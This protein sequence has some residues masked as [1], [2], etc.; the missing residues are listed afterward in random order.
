MIHVVA[1]ANGLRGQPEGTAELADGSTLPE[2]VMGRLAC[3]ASLVAH[4]LEGGSEPLVLGRKVRDWTPAQRRAIKVRDRGRCRFPGCHRGITDVHHI[5]PWE[6]GDNTDVSNG[7]LLCTRH[8][9]IVHQG[10]RVAGNGNGEL[11]F[12]RPDDSVL[13]TSLPS[14][15]PATLLRSA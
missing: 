3:D 13:G 9:T 15:R 4:L 6:E 1:D 5:V 14:R 11:V 8:H 2:G 12:R 7:A 10:F